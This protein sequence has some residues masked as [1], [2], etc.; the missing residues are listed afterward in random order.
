MEMGGCW[1][2][3]GKG[4]EGLVCLLMCFLF[5][6]MLLGCGVEEFLY[7]VLFVCLLKEP[8]SPLIFLV[9]L[10]SAISHLSLFPLGIGGMG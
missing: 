9:N 5:C 4:R 8:Q 3:V 6:L 1:E 7:C 10:G 2:W